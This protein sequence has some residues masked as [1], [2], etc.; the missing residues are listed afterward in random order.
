[1]SSPQYVWTAKIGDKFKGESKIEGAQDHIDLVQRPINPTQQHTRGRNGTGL[2][3]VG[4][5]MYDDIQIVSHWTSSSPGLRLLEDSDP[6][7]VEIV[8][9]MID[10][11]TKK[12]VKRIIWTVG[13]CAVHGVREGALDEEPDVFSLYWS[14][15]KTE[16]KK[17]DPTNGSLGAGTVVIYDRFKGVLSTS[18]S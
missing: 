14:T 11:Q 8:S 7:D 15:L 16:T 2:S 5:P 17:Q 6:V 12:P 3:P 13:N 1:M 9:W 4:V 10:P 18:A